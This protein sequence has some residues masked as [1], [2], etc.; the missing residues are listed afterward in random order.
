MVQSVVP[1]G[2]ASFANAPQAQVM[3]PASH[4][5]T[6]RDCTHMARSQASLAAADGVAAA[7]VFTHA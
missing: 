5:P 6:P 7:D 4:T 1:S 2:C 3:S